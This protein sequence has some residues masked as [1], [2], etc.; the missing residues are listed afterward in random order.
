MRKSQ[1][2]QKRQRGSGIFD[3][4]FGE[5]KQQQQETSS[6]TPAQSNVALPPIG[7]TTQLQQKGGVAPINMKDPMFFPTQR[8]MELATTAALPTKGGSR[9]RKRNKKSRRK[10]RR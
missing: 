8:Q 10:S 6:L 2:T 9:H 1:K 3:L 7:Q 5:K 4:L